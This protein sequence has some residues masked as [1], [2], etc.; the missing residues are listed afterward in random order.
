MLW[1]YYRTYP[2]MMKYLTTEE[3]FSYLHKSGWVEQ[4]MKEW[5]ES[6]MLKFV[7]NFDKR[8]MEYLDSS[9]GDNSKY[10]YR[11]ISFHAETNPT[12]A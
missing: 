7:E 2:L 11:Y 10:E 12:F 1:N 8:V 6:E 3:G 9:N 5:I 4:Q